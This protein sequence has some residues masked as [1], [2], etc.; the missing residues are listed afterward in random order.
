[1]LTWDTGCEPQVGKHALALL[2]GLHAGMI[3]KSQDWLLSRCTVALQRQLSGFLKSHSGQFSRDHKG[4]RGTSG[5]VSR[6]EEALAVRRSCL[7]LVFTYEGGVQEAKR[8]ARSQMTGNFRKR[9]GWRTLRTKSL[10]S[11]YALRYFPVL[12]YDL[13]LLFPI[14]LV[15]YRTGKVAGTL[16]EAW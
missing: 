9:T 15:W 7:I 11:S 2:C 1:M 4:R 10:R 13:K 5:Q 8:R 12:L 14:R 6:S 16:P 3:E